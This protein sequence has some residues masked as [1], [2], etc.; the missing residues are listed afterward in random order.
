MRERSASA[1]EA[2][3]AEMDEPT[4]LEHPPIEPR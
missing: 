2:V 4:P 3:R 1:A